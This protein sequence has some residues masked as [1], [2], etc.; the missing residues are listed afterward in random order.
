[1]E[2]RAQSVIFGDDTCKEQELFF[3][4]EDHLNSSGESIMMP[5][6]TSLQTDTY[7]NMFDA[8]IWNQ[9]TLIKEWKLKL[10][11]KGCGYIT[12]CEW[13]KKGISVL[14]EGEISSTQ[15]IN[16]YYEFEKEN[17]MIFF[18]I[19]AK[20]E[21]TIKKAYY[22]TEKEQCKLN[23]VHLSLVICTYNREQQIMKNLFKI[24]QSQFFDEKSEIFH[25]LS[26]RV[27][28]NASKFSWEN[29]EY[30]QVYKNKNTGG[31]GGFTRG[32]IESRREQE[33]FCISHII[34]M[35]DDVELMLETLYRIYAFCQLVQGKYKDDAIAGR[36]FR[37]DDRA[38]Q[39]TASE[40][41]NKS[42]IIHVD[43]NLDMRCRENLE[44]MNGEKG[45]YA[46]WWLAC[47]PMKFANTNLPLPFFLH[48]DDVEYGLRYSKPVLV[49]NGIQV[50]HETYE[51]RRIPLITYYD[52][53]NSL[54]VRTMYEQDID[55]DKIWKDWKY[56]LDL[57][58]NEKEYAFAYAAVKGL[59]DYLKGKENFFKRSKTIKRIYASK[60]L[61]KYRTAI[62]WRITYLKYKKKGE[63]AFLSYKTM[64]R[65]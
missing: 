44:E 14:A 36:M 9:G 3:R 7:L 63:K 28:D 2:V 43:G 52:I 51:Y 38:I 22:F 31:S 53:R 64:E 27:I 59:W 54:I 48:C 62:M 34:F 10:E 25:G 46:G 37:M 65:K 11:I 5:A 19:E 24:K 50:W 42:N 40:I 57:L 60:F 58:Y 16:R 1:M 33:R 32:I 47:Y 6:G 12:V 4:S 29:E 13:S 35:D 20:K 26:V 23:P 15:F 41:W 49:L 55:I 18:K 30:I 8:G 39:Y 61:I 21:L 17:G 56:R 45:E